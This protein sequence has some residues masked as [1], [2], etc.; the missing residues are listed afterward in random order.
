MNQNGGGGVGRRCT[1][2]FKITWDAIGKALS[3]FTLN[4]MKKNLKI[5]G[6]GS[7]QPGLH[8]EML[9]LLAV[10]RMNWQGHEL[11]LNAQIRGGTSEEEVFEGNEVG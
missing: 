11:E 9:T 4:V 5:S 6:R 7:L 1:R 10:W 2:I 3:I 8:W